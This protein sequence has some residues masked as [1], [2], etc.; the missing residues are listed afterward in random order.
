MLMCASQCK[1]IFF[2]PFQ[3]FIMLISMIQMAHFYPTKNTVKTNN[4]WTAIMHYSDMYV[5]ITIFYI[6]NINPGI[7]IV[8]GL[9]NIDI[10]RVK[11]YIYIFMFYPIYS[12][13]RFNHYIY[14]L[15]SLIFNHPLSTKHYYCFNVFFIQTT[16]NSKNN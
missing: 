14:F 7:S 8:E 13:L 1:I 12:S 3:V 16:F 15:G 6:R 9:N 11:R 2:T 4:C 10:V 5:F